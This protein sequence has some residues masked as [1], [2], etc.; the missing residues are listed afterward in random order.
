MRYM[1]LHYNVFPRSHYGKGEGTAYSVDSESCTLLVCTIL[2]FSRSFYTPRWYCSRVCTVYYV[3]L[4]LN[5]LSLSERLPASTSA[6]FLATHQ[7]VERK[8]GISSGGISVSGC[9]CY[10]TQ[11]K[12]QSFSCVSRHRTTRRKR[13]CIHFSLPHSSPFFFSK[14]IPR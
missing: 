3:S 7:T 6:S 14:L 1:L 4:F 9:R 13:K 5:S 12:L 11:L 10:R 2:W 8:R